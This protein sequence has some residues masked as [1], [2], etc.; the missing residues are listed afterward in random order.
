MKTC[1]GLENKMFGYVIKLFFHVT[2]NPNNSVRYTYC[3]LYSGLLFD[4][5]IE[6]KKFIDFI[7]IFKDKVIQAQ[8]QFGLNLSWLL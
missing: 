8:K 5:K 4:E 6:N 7:W 3:V 1:V 2:K